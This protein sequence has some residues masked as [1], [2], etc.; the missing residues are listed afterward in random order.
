MN[1]QPDGTVLTCYFVAAHCPDSPDA[2]EAVGGF[3]IFFQFSEQC[4][5]RR[6]TIT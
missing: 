4:M 1:M 6:V 5:L 3:M 2:S